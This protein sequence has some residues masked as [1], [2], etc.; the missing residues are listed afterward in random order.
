MYQETLKKY[1]LS[2]SKI[3]GHRSNLDDYKK[4]IRKYAKLFLLCAF[5]SLACLQSK[6]KIVKWTAASLTLIPLVQLAR[7]G[8]K[9]RGCQKE[10]TV[11]EKERRQLAERLHYYQ[12]FLK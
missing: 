11:L 9:K 8:S 4:N 3:L 2:N 7:Y 5:A 12:S 1:E 10:L 6:N